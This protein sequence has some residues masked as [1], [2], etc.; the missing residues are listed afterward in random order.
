[1]QAAP[2]LTD[3]ALGDALEARLARLWSSVL[4]TSSRELSRTATSVLARLR[5]D[6][7]QRVGDLAAAEAV[8]QPTMTTLLGRLERQGLVARHPDPGDGRA[9]RVALTDAGAATLRRLGRERAEALRAR[10]A[11]LDE[12]ER[13][14]LAAALPVLDRLTTT[15]GA[16]R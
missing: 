6:G 10:L 13:A 4:R 15:N 5:D 12:E 7:P 2:P 16:G 11:V 9:V 3:A 8:A 1:M 14:V